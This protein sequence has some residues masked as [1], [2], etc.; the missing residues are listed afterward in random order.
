MLVYSDENTKIIVT[1]N[2]IQHKV[3]IKLSNKGAYIPPQKLEIIFEKYA[4][5][6]LEQLKLVV[7]D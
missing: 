6:K 3:I 1:A 5:I 4:W 2:V 7:Q